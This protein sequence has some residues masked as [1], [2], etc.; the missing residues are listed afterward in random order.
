MVSRYIIVATGESNSG[1]YALNSDASAGEV[2]SRS[3][4]K[5]WNVTT[6]TFENLDIGTNNNLDHSGLNSTT[7]GMELQLANDVAAGVWA[8][9]PMYYVQTGQGASQ[10]SEW[11][12]GNASQYWTKFLARINAVK[13]YCSANDIQPIWVVWMSFGINDALAGTASGTWITDTT[14]WINRIKTELP[15]CRI[16]MTELTTA[17]SAYTAHVRTLCNNESNVTFAATTGC[18]ERDSNHWSYA[19]MKTLSTRMTRATQIFLGIRDGAIFSNYTS[20]VYPVDR[21]L[22][23]TSST[24]GGTISKELMNISSPVWSVEW[25]T[26]TLSDAIVV[27]LE[28]TKDTSHSWG[29]GQTF[30][31]GAYNVSGNIIATT[32]GAAGNTTVTAIGDRI[33][34]TKSGNNLLI[35][36]QSAGTW[37]TVYTHT[38]VLS[39][40]STAYLHVINAAAAAADEI[41]LTVT[42]S[43]SI[44]VTSPIGTDRRIVGVAEDITW[45]AFGTES[46]NVL[47]SLDGGSTYPI[48]LSSTNTSGT[49]SW[50]PTSGQIAASAKIKVVST[51]DGSLYGES[52]SFRVAT[53]S[54]SGGTNTGLWFRLQELAVNDGLELSRP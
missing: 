49:Y 12:V 4:V 16:I 36:K 11:S 3:E 40:I 34:L 28:S 17:R 52:S 26:N 21:K 50:T 6:S 30:I 54:S 14:A 39:G 41:E 51:A 2:A 31:A 27:A 33:R 44:T 20:N 35:W 47:L 10:I 53:T 5:M 45:S 23:W 13:S 32:N 42:Q 22:I 43:L 15:D 38:G 48:T 8:Q 46:V 7:H 18:T 29:G 19:G 24:V 1:G 25:P 37:T 9:N